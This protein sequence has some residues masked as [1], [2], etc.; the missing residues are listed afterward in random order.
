[1]HQQDQPKSTGA[2]APHRTLI[3]YNDTRG[4]FC[5]HYHTTFT[6]T[7]PK[8]QKDTDNLTDFLRFLELHT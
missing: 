2:K 1:M 7:D 8:A 4:Q 3:T 5:Q 6:Q